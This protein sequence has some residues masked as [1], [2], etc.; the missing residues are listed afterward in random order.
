MLAVGRDEH[1]VE[2]GLVALG[3]VLVAEQR[4]DADQFGRRRHRQHQLALDRAAA[5]FRH[6]DEDLGL[7]RPGRG[8]RL[9]ERHGKVA[10]PLSSASGR[11]SI[12][13]RS[14]LAVSSSATPN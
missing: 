4:L 9:G 14:L 10:T 7:L 8:R 11:F 12:G 6:A 5:G 1:D 13:V 3:D 2:I